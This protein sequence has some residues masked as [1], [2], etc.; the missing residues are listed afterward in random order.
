LV[1]RRSVVGA[2]WTVGV[3]YVLLGIEATG[4]AAARYPARL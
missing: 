3:L 1:A 2:W 4:T